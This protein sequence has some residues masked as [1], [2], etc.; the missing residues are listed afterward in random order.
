M[1][2]YIRGW[3]R[4]ILSE[5]NISYPTNLNQLKNRVKKDC[6]ARGLGRSYGDSSIQPKNTI[7]MTYLDKVIYFNKKK[8]L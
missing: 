8:E 5:V 4:N 3:G 7:V 1:K 6:I 2:K